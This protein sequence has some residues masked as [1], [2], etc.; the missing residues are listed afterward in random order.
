M[1]ASGDFPMGRL[2]AALSVLFAVAGHSPLHAEEF[3]WCTEFDAFTRN[4]A[5]TSYDECVAV[6]KTAG[7][8]CVRNANY[9]PA[10]KPAPRNAAHKPH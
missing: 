9:R 8:T 6:A 2:I 10:P 4:C 1:A 7:V 3:P 5:F